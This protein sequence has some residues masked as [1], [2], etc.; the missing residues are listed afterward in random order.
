[1]TDVKPAKA[2]RALRIV[3]YGLTTIV[4]GLALLSIAA[5]RPPKRVD[6][7]GRCDTFVLPGTVSWP[8]PAVDSVQLRGFVFQL[9][10]VQTAK[11]SGLMKGEHWIDKRPTIPFKVN[12]ARGP[13]PPTS[14]VQGARF[15]ADSTLELPAG[16]LLSGESADPSF[17]PL[18]RAVLPHG[19]A[20]LL[21]L[22]ADALKFP[23]MNRLIPDGVDGVRWMQLAETLVADVRGDGHRLLSA[24]FLPHKQQSDPPEITLRLSNEAAIGQNDV[25]D[26]WVTAS[27]QPFQV[28]LTGCLDPIIKVDQ[29]NSP[30]Q[31]KDVP[32]P[33]WIAGTAIQLDSLRVVK[34]E[35][36][37][38]IPR[39][40]LMIRISANARSVLVGQT[41]LLP[42]RL[43]EFLSGTWQERGT[44]GLALFLATCGLVVVLKKV[45]EKT[46]DTLIASAKA[47]LAKPSGDDSPR[48]LDAHS[49]LGL[50]DGR[51]VSVA[52]LP[53]LE[54]AAVVRGDAIPEELRAALCALI[55]ELR[56]VASETSATADV[57]RMSNDVIVLVNE[58]ASLSKRVQWCLFCLEDLIDLS[59]T[60]GQRAE[61]VAVEARS[62]RA[63]LISRMPS[64]TRV[65]GAGDIKAS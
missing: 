27:E 22:R 12:A 54:A 3:L 16:T 8:F 24:D 45:V 15:G 14:V 1:M 44:V 19:G 11:I 38:K 17:G 56:G 43:G 51:D 10:N 35:T 6:I 23:E 50:H 13:E 29:Q 33:I 61:F 34:D 42:T 59:P 25:S 63:Q 58:L 65:T 26:H 48:A 4:A 39:S 36:S 31:P 28:P 57:L 46:A 62:L 49:G 52:H 47:P 21:K 9:T 37:A 55:S 18:V 32:Y 20:A 64:H 2:P 53:L 60:L 40:K 30:Q 7:T 5:M 41:E